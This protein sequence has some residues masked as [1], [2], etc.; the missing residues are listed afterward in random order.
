MASSNFTVHSP[1]LFTGE[2]YQLWAI[3]MKTYLKA[4]NLWE[5]IENDVD[6]ASLPQNPTLAQIRRYE[7]DLSR[8]PRAL[9]CIHSTV[10]VVIFT[11]IMTCDS[12]KQAWD[13]LKEEFEGSDMVKSVKMLT[14]KREFETL[15]MK[16]G[17]TAKE[18]S[19][20]LMQLVNQIRL[21]GETFE[22]SKVV[23]KN[24]DKLARQI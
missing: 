11:R 13:K 22:D 5:V 8:K 24:V 9:T 3:K 14:L 17:E 12:P 18:Y 16:N 20:K 21:Y 4:M 10:S 7:E 19:S 15:R 23:K 6:P 2:N 1:P